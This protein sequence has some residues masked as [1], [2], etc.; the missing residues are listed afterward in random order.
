MAK[1]GL[2]LEGIR[3]IEYANYVAAPVTGRL[4]ADWGAEVIKIEPKS[5]DSMRYVGMQWNFPIDELENPLFE[6]ENSGKRDILIDTNTEEGIELVFKLLDSADIFLTN[7]RQK[8][9]D[10][11]GLNYEAVKARAPHIIYGHLLGYGD[12]G[13]AKDNP[14]FDYTAYFARGGVALGL[15]EKGTS[16]CNPVAGLGDHAAGM[17]LAAGILAALNKQK[18]TGLG[19]RVTVSLFHTAVFGMGIMVSAAKYDYQMPITRRQPPNPLN[20]TYECADGA[21]VQLAFFQYDK[22]FPGFCDIVIERPDLKGSKYST[23]KSAVLHTEEF[24][25]MM[26][27]EFIKRPFAEWA[28][29]LQKAGIPYEK[30]ATPSDVLNDEQCWANDYL[31]RHTYENGNEG[32]IY[33]TPV[34]F[35]ENPRGE[36][37]RAPKMGEHT[38]EI[39]EEMGLSAEEIENLKNSEIIK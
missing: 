16:P 38:E 14:A 22:W 32:V 11:S 12:N 9:L 23:M 17:S 2:P 24:V 4:L 20:T 3:V 7:T 39:L 29:R 5:G 21:W 1:S 33:N 18:E 6:I 36:Y 30:L 10:K 15:M 26:E 28:E 8:A 13:P 25:I 35:T 37:V 19:E 31:I 34:M 27:E